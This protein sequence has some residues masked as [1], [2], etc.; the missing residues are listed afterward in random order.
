MLVGEEVS[1][2]ILQIKI[3]SANTEIPPVN[4]PPT[5]TQPHPQTP[6][7]RWHY[8]YNIV[9]SYAKRGSQN[10]INQNVTNADYWYCNNYECLKKC[11]DKLVRDLYQNI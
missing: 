5:P 2:R 11:N 8:K 4:C 7:Q 6:S 9:G 10:I 3:D 1:H